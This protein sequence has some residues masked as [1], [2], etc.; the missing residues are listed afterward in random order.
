MGYKSLPS[1]EVVE[2]SNFFILTQFARITAQLSSMNSALYVASRSLVSLAKESRAPKFFAKTTKNGTPVNALVFSNLLGLIAMLNY[3]AGPGKVFSYLITI[4]G[5][6]TYIAWAVIGITHIRFRK[7][8]AV[9]GHRVEDLPFKALWYP[10][11]T[12]FVVFIN[13][14]LV[15]IAGYSVFV[16]GFHAV[17][18]VINYLVIAVFVV[19]FCGWKIIKGTKIVPLVEMDLKTGRRDVPGIFV[20]SDGDQEVKTIPFYVKAKQ[21]VSRKG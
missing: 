19:L 21:L 3:K 10:Y 6:A 11:G 14:F 9:Q 8:W 4:S 20:E 15:F 16:D 1:P 13:T 5:S 17:D 12:I 7:G 18:F 2:K